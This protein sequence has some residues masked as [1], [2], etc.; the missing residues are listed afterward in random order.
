MK[1]RLLYTFIIIVFIA[2]II[3]L[4]KYAFSNTVFNEGTEKL[5][6]TNQKEI[7]L[8]P[9]EKETDLYPDEKETEYVYPDS[10]DGSN[11]ENREPEYE[12]IELKSRIENSTYNST[13]NRKG[14]A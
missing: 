10:N 7:D 11:D 12:V 8:Y 3:L 5:N 6:H 1:K 4:L 9:D 2:G 14:F 13:Y